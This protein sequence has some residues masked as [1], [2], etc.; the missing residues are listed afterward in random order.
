M[1][2]I[3][4]ATLEDAETI[5]A[6]QKLAYQSEAKL[7]NDWSLPPLTQT[8]ESLGE[9]FRTSVI[10]KATE[11]NRIV[12]SVRAKVSGGTCAIGRLIVHPE[13]QGQGIGSKLL[14]AIEASCAGVARFELFTGSK[15]EANIRLYQRHGYTITRTQTISPT[16]TLTFLEKPANTAL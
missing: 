5:L 6:L 9:E 4:R 7:Y 1:L 2:T 15:S 8:L 16:V 12:G 11:D 13:F 3:D 10:L 14:Q